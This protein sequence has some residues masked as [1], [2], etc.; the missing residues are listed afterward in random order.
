MC[1]SDL[2]RVA[3][4]R[5]R[6]QVR[7]QSQRIKFLDTQRDDK[8]IEIAAARTDQRLIEVVDFFDDIFRLKA[9]AELSHGFRA[10]LDNQNL[11]R[12]IG[13]GQ[14]LTRVD[15]T[16]ALT[17]FDAHPEFVGHHLQ[18][19]QRTNAREKCKIVNRLRKKIVRPSVE[20]SNQVGRLV[21]R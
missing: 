10:I 11:A 4:F 17:G 18:T 13:V 12:R 20:P 1:S 6:A 15:K 7:T 21:E 16:H 5:K 14:R 9:S 3:R 8:Q 2:R 19:H